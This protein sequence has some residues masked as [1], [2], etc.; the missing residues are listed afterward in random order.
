M[1]R[2]AELRLGVFVLP[3]HAARLRGQWRCR[4]PLAGFRAR[5]EPARSAAETGDC[6]AFRFFD[7]IGGEVFDAAKE[8][9]GEWTD[10]W[11]FGAASTPH[12]VSINRRTYRTLH[13]VESLAAKL[14]EGSREDIGEMVE[15]SVENAALYDEHTW[16]ADGSVTDSSCDSS[17]TGRHYKAHFAQEADT[18]SKIARAEVLRRVGAAVVDPVPGRSMMIANTLGWSRTETIEIPVPWLRRDVVPT[19]AHQHR[20]QMLPVAWPAESVPLPTDLVPARYVGAD[21]VRI[22][23]GLDADSQKRLSVEDIY[24]RGTPVITTER[25]GDA[26]TV[27]NQHFSVFVALD[28]GISS[29][30]QKSDGREWISR[31]PMVPVGVPLRESP[32]EGHRNAIHQHPD[33]TRFMGFKGFS[34]DWQADRVSCSP[35]ASCT[36]REA[37]GVVTLRQELSS[38]FADGGFLEIRLDDSRP[39]I[40]LTVGMDFRWDERPCTWYLPLEF[41]LETPVFDYD[42]CGAAMRLGRDQ[43][44]DANMDFFTVDRWVKISD[45]QDSVLIAPLDTPIV[46]LGGLTFGRMTTAP[47]NGA[48]CLRLG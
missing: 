19:L 24:E 32:V 38:P 2:E 46:S 41:A 12:E 30:V 35:G 17:R 34:T 13:D 8:H 23:V 14:T 20:M 7:A 22:E 29:I 28:G 31:S 42:N 26:R 18:F 36:I 1:A 3:G 25:A 43:V 37:A 9:A 39:L 5:V 40:E 11:N 6:D 16:G 44:P 47:P 4:C 15:S 27:S 21:A 10:F 45:A 48:P 33:Y